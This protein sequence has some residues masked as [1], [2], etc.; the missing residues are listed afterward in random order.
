MLLADIEAA[1]A[2]EDAQIRRFHPRWREGGG[3]RSALA[4]APWRH[5][6]AGGGTA[7]LNSALSRLGLV[8]EEAKGPED[9]PA[10]QAPNGERGGIAARWL[11]LR[12]GSPIAGLSAADILLRRRH[13][14]SLL[15]ISRRGG[16]ISRLRWTRFAAAMCCCCRGHRRRLPTSPPPPGRYLWRIGRLL[17][18]IASAAPRAAGVLLPLRCLPPSACCRQPWPSPPARCWWWRRASCRCDGCMRRVDW[19]VVVLLGALIPVAA[20]METTGAAA[21]FAEAL[22]SLIGPGSLVLVCGADALH[23]DTGRM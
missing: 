21:L 11:V 8:I 3:A 2:K 14:V 15:A 17:C 16:S 4:R 1:L 9:E 10:R 18:P 5:P 20:A 6:G 23:G 7:R 22:L 12:P 13:G 19:S